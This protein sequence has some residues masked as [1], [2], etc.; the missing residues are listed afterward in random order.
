[1]AAVLLLVSCLTGVAAPAP[2]ALSAPSAPSARPLDEYAWVDPEETAA[3]LARLAAAG[4]ELSPGGDLDR[5]PTAMGEMDG[6]GRESGDGVFQVH[7]LVE[8]L[9]V[10]FADRMGQIEE[11]VPRELV[12]FCFLSRPE[13]P[14]D[15]G[16]EFDRERSCPHQ[17]VSLAADF[18]CGPRRITREPSEVARHNPFRLGE[19][20][21]EILGN[22]HRLQSHL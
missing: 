12:C 13:K 2:S 9:G 16:E 17:D 11:Y 3:L 10:R 8:T 18:D 14:P 20:V 6:T 15:Q 5:R 4:V 1:M 22:V 7:L 19:N 21:L